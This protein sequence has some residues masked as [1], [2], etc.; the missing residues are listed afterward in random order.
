MNARDIALFFLLKDKNGVVFTQNLVDKNGHTFYDG[1]ARLNKFLQLA[2][3]I[4]YAKYG[5]LLFDDDLL[6]YDNGGVV[7]EVQKAYRY[8]CYNKNK[9]AGSIHIDDKAKRF[10]DVFYTIFKDAPVDE[11]IDLSHE[12]DAWLEKHRFGT[13]TNLLKMDTKKY[14]SDY[15]KQYQDILNVM[16]AMG[17]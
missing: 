14:L 16:E 9:L 11:L 15:K 17:A 6:A 7:P 12:D 2:R 4:Y 5:E 13:K 8:L 1:N 10:L 3:N